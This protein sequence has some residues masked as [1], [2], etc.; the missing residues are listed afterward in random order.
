MSQLK[1]VA[2]ETDLTDGAMLDG[3]AVLTVTSEAFTANMVDYVVDV[4]ASRV[5]TDG[6]MDV[7]NVVVHDGAITALGTT[8]TC[9]TSAPFHAGMVGDAIVVAGAGV[10]GGDLTT[11]IA[12][13]T[14]SG[15]VEL[16]DAAV[17]TVT[18]ADVT[19]TVDATSLSCDT[20]APFTM[21]MV[22]ADIVVAGADTGGDDLFTTIATYVSAKS[23][24]LT[25][26]AVTSV[27]NATVTLHNIYNLSTSILSVDS[28]TQVTLNDPSAA[29]FDFTAAN[30]T[31][32]WAGAAYLDTSGYPFVTFSAPLS[33][34]T[35]SVKVFLPDGQ[36][37]VLAN[38][39]NGVNT[40]LSS[41]HPSRTYFGG[42][43]YALE[44][45]GTDDGASLYCDY[46]S[47]AV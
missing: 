24:T 46:G 19:I 13:F 43:T 32:S 1:V 11:T 15:H 6:H 26:P 38:D 9:A 31:I 18:G 25:A 36:S 27:N 10:A 39:V 20:S 23:V 34:D 8:L 37:A 2:G 4:A 30:V 33:S 22:G 35:I 40:G 7:T 3:S 41:T 14:D 16:T 21:A 12:S 28:A 44:I 45:S 5:V 29:G 42:P 47:R 17:T